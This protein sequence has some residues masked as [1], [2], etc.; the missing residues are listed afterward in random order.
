[1][2]SCV[3]CSPSSASTA[4]S[5]GRRVATANVVDI[6]GSMAPYEA[7]ITAREA[8][9]DHRGVSVFLC[10]SD[11][12]RFDVAPRALADQEALQPGWLYFVLPTSMLRLALSGHEMATLVVR[13][14]AALAVAGGVAS[15]PQRKNAAGAH[16]KRLKT[17][18]V[19][20]LVASHKEYE[21]ANGATR[22][23]ANDVGK[24]T[25]AKTRKRVGVRRL[26]DGPKV[27]PHFGGR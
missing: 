1:M 6:D 4:G 26:Q 27:E 16:G 10:S 8:L 25:V 21:L 5:S 17:A 13:A 15:P 18:R 20:P 14:S 23:T 2:G 3:S 7:P 9:G 22:K 12:L 24:E 11:E 19:S